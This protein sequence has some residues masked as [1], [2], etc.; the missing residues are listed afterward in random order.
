[1]GIL[2]SLG[3][4]PRYKES[5]HDAYFGKTQPPQLQAVKGHKV[6]CLRTGKMFIQSNL[7]EVFLVPKW[8]I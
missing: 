6:L 3:D 1:M 2:I 4:G 7:G 8:V 5:I